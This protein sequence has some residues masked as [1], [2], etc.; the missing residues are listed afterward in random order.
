M[1]KLI[2]FI[3]LSSLNVLSPSFVARALP[4]KLCNAELVLMSCAPLRLRFA[5]YKSILG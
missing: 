4:N 2:H 5:E 3:Y 1:P